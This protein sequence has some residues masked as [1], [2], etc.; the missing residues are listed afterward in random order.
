MSR[1]VCWFDLDK[2]FQE[3][4]AVLARAR[5]ERKAMM[6]AD[7]DATTTLESDTDRIFGDEPAEIE[8]LRVSSP[9]ATEPDGF[10]ALRDDAE[11]ATDPTGLAEVRASSNVPTDPSLEVARPVDEQVEATSENAVD[12]DLGDLG[13]TTAE[14]SSG[15]ATTGSL[16]TEKLE[17]SSGDAPAEEAAPAAEQREAHFEPTPEGL[18]AW[19]AEAYGVEESFLADD[20][21]GAYAM[22]SLGEDW[23]KAAILPR[24][25]MLV[26]RSLVDMSEQ[27][28]VWLELPFPYNRAIQMIWTSTDN[29]MVILGMLTEFPLFSDGVER[30]RAKVNAV[31]AGL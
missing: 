10:A 27:G 25:I 7:P 1:S 28:N 24:P 12:V 19:V 6:A 23:I 20:K 15:E 13:A 2:D 30:A 29:G 8:D 17:P 3:V 9:V 4:T 22:R 31:I 21:G 18:L 11:D 5:A 16:P 26:S 14:P